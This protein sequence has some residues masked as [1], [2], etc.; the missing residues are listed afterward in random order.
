MLLMMLS[1]LA[2]GIVFDGY[3][4]VAG[5]FRFPRWTVPLLDLM[6]WLAA[7]LFV[8]QMLVKGNQGELRFYV[9]LGLAAGAWLYVILLSKV[10]VGIVTWLVRAILSISRFIRRCLY[11]LLVLP[12]KGLWI[13]TKGLAS[14]LL[15]PA[16]FLGKIVLQCVK[17]LWLLIRWIFRP[18]ILPIWERLGMTERLRWIKQ[19]VLSGIRRMNQWAASRRAMAAHLLRRFHRKK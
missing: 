19:K 18:L 2:L 6:Y 7:T 15:S 12:L 13:F 1:G 3:R 10:T 17:P 11:V 16:M 8:F 14:F 4:V 5:Q 9:F